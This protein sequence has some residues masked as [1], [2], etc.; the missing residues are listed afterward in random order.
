[1]RIK[2][3]KCKTDEELSKENLEE[4]VGLVE[5][6]GLEAIDYI[7]LLTVIRGKCTDGKS[8]T[9]TFHESF[10]DEVNN[11]VKRNKDNESERQNLKKSVDE[12]DKNIIELTN[13]LEETRKN[14]ENM[15]EQLV[16]KNDVEMELLDE[17]Q[18]LTGTRKINMWS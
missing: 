13:K 3:L 10:T 9:Y 15:L 1:M 14:R 18:K 2:C 12:A 5:K 16:S 7:R 11:V 8:H 6:H 4:I 17:I